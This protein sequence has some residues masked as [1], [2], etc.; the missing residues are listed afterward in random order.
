M[1]LIPTPET[2]EPIAHIV[3]NAIIE[4]C[5]AAVKDRVERMKNLWETLWENDRATPA[6]ILMA[7]GTNAATIFQAA[8]LARTDLEAIAN[9]ANTTSEALLGDAKY[10]TTAFPVTI[11]NNGTAILS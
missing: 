5:N 4:G 10:L 7:L 9:L 1:N 2:P 11:E 8:A 3:A 6:E